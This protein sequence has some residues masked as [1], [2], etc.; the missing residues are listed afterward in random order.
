MIIFSIIGIVVVVWLVFDWIN[1][2][3]K[4]QNTFK[5]EQTKIIREA[6]NNSLDSKP[7]LL[8]DGYY[9][10]HYSGF[11]REGNPVKSTMV[12]IFIPQDKA[13]FVQASDG[14]VEPDIRKLFEFVTRLKFGDQNLSLDEYSLDGGK[15]ELFGNILSFEVGD[16]FSRI[17]VTGHIYSEFL[18]LT[19]FL[20]KHYVTDMFD[21]LPLIESANFVYK[22]FLV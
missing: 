8:E 17:K 19:V 1:K 6:P 16:Y 20:K 2:S 21:S 7:V 4:Q 14:I 9:L 10:M 11:N 15:Y 18:T 3:S 13:V 5:Q 22:P 12:L